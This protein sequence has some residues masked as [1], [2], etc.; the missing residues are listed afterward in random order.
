[1]AI[2][3][4]IRKR[5]EDNSTVEYA[6]GPSEEELV[7]AVRLD[8]SDGRIELLELSSGRED[9]YLPRVSHILKRCF[10]SGQFPNATCFAA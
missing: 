4:A 7:G 5:A 6:F 2:Y 10:T 3:I 1:M 8:K 9:F